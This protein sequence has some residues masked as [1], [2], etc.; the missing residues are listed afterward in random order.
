MGMA[1]AAA[2]TVKVEGVAGMARVTAGTVVAGKTR[3]AVGT[4][5]VAVGERARAML[6]KVVAVVF[7]ARE[8]GTLGMLRPELAIGVVVV[9]ARPRVRLGAEVSALDKEE[10]AAELTWTAATVRVKTVMENRMMADHPSELAAVE[11]TYGC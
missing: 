1:V 2:A 5:R 7:V 4:A 11:L 10:M 8:A 3:T 9:V 6:T